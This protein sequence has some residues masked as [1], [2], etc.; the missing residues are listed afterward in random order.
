ME[1]YMDEIRSLCSSMDLNDEVIENPKTDN[2]MD[3]KINGVKDILN[4]YNCFFFDMDGVF[5]RGSE[6]IQAA[7]EAFKLLKANNKKVYFVTNNCT[8][9]RQTYVEK[10]KGVG[11]ETPKEN[12]F[13]AS[14]IV[15]EYIKLKHPEVKK[16]YVV[17][18]K[19]ICD[20][21]DEYGIPYLDS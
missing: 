17:G 2:K 16:A 11:V 7:V 5:W 21:L 12:V 20:E 3:N 10:L 4:Q 8:R 19:G 18:M 13:A 9:S 14:S 15:A 1:L 6:T